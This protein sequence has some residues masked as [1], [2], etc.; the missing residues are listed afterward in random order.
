MDALEF[1]F[2]GFAVFW[3]GLFAYLLWLQG[4]LRAVSR[5]LERLQERLAEHALERSPER[6]VE[7]A[8]E[9]LGGAGAETNGE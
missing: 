9:R 8:L 1:L 4:R 2:A 6:P 5:E 7:H 3:G